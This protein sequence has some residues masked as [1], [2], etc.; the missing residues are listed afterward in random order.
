MGS[1]FVRFRRRIGIESMPF[2]L[3][4]PFFQNGTALIFLDLVF[5]SFRMQAPFLVAGNNDDI[6]QASWV[7]VS[8]TKTFWRK[9][10]KDNDVRYPR[11]LGEWTGT[12]FEKEYDLNC[13]LVIKIE[14]SFL[15]IG[16]KF[17]T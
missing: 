8:T 15:G 12:S 3:S 11:Q 4:V 13:S 2:S 6:I 17:M 9:L 14:D 1:V 16:D 10:F 5:V 7:D